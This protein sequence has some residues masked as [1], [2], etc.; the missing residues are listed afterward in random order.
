[1]LC[2]VPFSIVCLLLI[3]NKCVSD[4]HIYGKKKGLD[5]Y[6]N[7]VLNAT[8]AIPKNYTILFEYVGS[9][10]SPLVDYCKITTNVNSTANFTLVER[11]KKI[12]KA[13]IHIPN[14]MNV[15]ASIELSGDA[16]EFQHSLQFSK[17]FPEHASKNAES[18]SLAM[19]F[20]KNAV[21]SV[22]AKQ[23]SQNAIGVRQYGDELLYFESRNVTNVSRFPSR[24][25]EY[26]EDDK[27]HITYVG[28]SFNSPTAIAFINSTFILKQELSAIAYDMN[29]EHF[30][31]NVSIYGFR[32][33][34]LET[35]YKEIIES[36]EIC[37]WCNYY[38]KY[39]TSCGARTSF[40]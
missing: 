36:K 3:L 25:F 19:V 14:A 15:T 8:Q 35:T 21:P 28:F 24:S 38:K 5:F 39:P 27:T 30:M 17:V 12:V 4:E 9:A 11:E 32:N 23:Y 31:A 33:F 26:V 2:Y 34:G 16:A 37:C 18:R 1:M 10:T 29:T 22:E 40:D 7:K 13:T 6:T 20:V